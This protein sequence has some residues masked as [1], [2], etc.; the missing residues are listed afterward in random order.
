MLELSFLVTKEDYVFQALEK[1]HY[2]TPKENKIILYVIGLIAVGCGT[3]AWLHLNGSI[4]QKTGFA[5]LILS[6]LYAVCYYDIIKPLLVKRRA[7]AY[8]E[9]HQ[10]YIGSKRVRLYAD[11][12]EVIAENRS[13]HLPQKYI[14]RIVEGKHSLLVFLDRNESVFLPKRVFSEQQLTEFRSVYQE[15]CVAN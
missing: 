8:Y 4:Y 3:A 10:K 13:L 6:G 11:K 14:Y 9:I 15:N 5:A 1:Q 12:I 7:A 2:L